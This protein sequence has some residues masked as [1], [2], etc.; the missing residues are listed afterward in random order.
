MDF[1]GQ[2]VLVTGASR[3]IGAATAKYFASKHATVVVN[4]AGS[5]QKAEEVVAQIKEMGAEAMAIQCNVADMSACQNMIDQVI[6]KYGRVDVLVNN[7]GITKDNLILKMTEDDFDAVIATNL[8]GCFNTIKCLSKIMLKQKY[9]RIVNL[10]SV[11]GLHGIPGQANYSASKAGVVGLTMSIAKELA[12]RNI[13]CNAVAP[14]FIETDMTEA[15]TEAARE[16][17]LSVVP[18]KR[19]GKPEEV[20]ALIAFL[21]SKEASYITGQVVEISGGM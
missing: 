1:S 17:A 21:G 9:G 10:S 16:A 13:T 4:Y 12:S 5:V 8:K 18:M 19:G 15:M 14:G 7:A 11:S 20:A 3:G 6:E 2:V